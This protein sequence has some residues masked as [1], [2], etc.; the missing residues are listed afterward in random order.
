VNTR[1]YLLVNSIP[2]KADDN[3]VG[4]QTL[5]I[6]EM[7]VSDAGYLVRANAVAEATYDDPAAQNRADAVVL[8]S[9]DFSDINGDVRIDV[10]VTCQAQATATTQ[11]GGLS[12]GEAT[13]RPQLKPA[14]Q[15]QD[16]EVIHNVTRSGSPGMV[17]SLS[18]ST[19]NSQGGESTATVGVYG[20]D[21]IPL[22]GYSDPYKAP[23]GTFEAWT[24]FRPDD[25]PRPLPIE[26]F[27]LYDQLNLVEGFHNLE[28]VAGIWDEASGELVATSKPFTFTIMHSSGA[29]EPWVG[30][31]GSASANLKAFVAFI[32]EASNAE[33]YALYNLNA[34]YVR[35]Y[36][37][38]AALQ[39]VN[40]D[41]A[42]LL[43]SGRRL[44]ATFDPK[45]SYIRNIEA[46]GQDKVDVEYCEYWQ[47]TVYD[48]QT[49][50]VVNQTPLTAVPQRITL[51]VNGG[52][53]YITGFEMHDDPT[54]CKP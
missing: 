7:W 2:L 34:D 23:D 14:A 46:A 27:V 1:H 50:Q 13:P 21:G 18:V 48:A 44:V 15:I 5:A 45:R 10:P 33:S 17:I 24:T 52:K 40:D 4:V 41:I 30:V 11:S 26:V 35:D 38:G 49:S 19:Q 8:F 42:T 54:L 43:S 29:A 22:L 39:K 32:S 28:L 12:F 20:P 25:S 9:I 3:G 53:T 31:N 6:G 16:V 37:S 47:N 36:Y 51:W